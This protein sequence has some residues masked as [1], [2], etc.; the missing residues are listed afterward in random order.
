MMRRRGGMRRRVDIKVVYCER[1][2][3]RLHYIECA[4]LGGERAS[5]IQAVT[6]G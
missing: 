3:E 1:S 2:E 6:K 4:P 5:H